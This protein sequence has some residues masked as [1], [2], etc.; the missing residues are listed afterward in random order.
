M[1]GHYVLAAG[2]ALAA[3][4]LSIWL[5]P[6]LHGD[7]PFLLLTGAVL[8]AAGIGGVGPGLTATALCAGFSMLL[9]AEAI[10]PAATSFGAIMFVA[11]GIGI[12]VLSEGPRRGIVRLSSVNEKLRIREGH[13]AAVLGMAPD[14]IV[15]IDGDGHI[16][17]FNAAAE[18]LF[19]YRRE[20]VV[21]QN[22]RI[23]MP[24]P[25]RDEHDGYLRHYRETGDRKI[26]GTGRVVV[27]ERKNGSTFPMSLDV[28]EMNVDGRSLFTGFVKD[29]TERQQSDARLHELRAELVHAA[30][31][32]AMGE[33]ASALAHE[34]NQPLSAIANYMKGLLRSIQGRSSLD[35]AQI[36]TA[37][38]KA[39][40]QALRA[41]GIVRRLRDFVARGETD[42]QVESLSKLVNEASALGLV[43]VQQSGVKP[44]ISVPQEAGLVLV[45]R[46]QIQQVLFNLMRNAIEAMVEAQ[47]STRMLL[48]TARAVDGSLVE[49]SVADTG[50]GISPEVADRLFRPFT[51][52][53]PQGMGLGL[54]ISRTIVEAHGGR[55]WVEAAEGGG[56]V[57]RFT[58][59]AHV[60]EG[61][62]DGG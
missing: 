41:G 54:S 4:G 8:V 29:L 59:R 37:L 36:A 60:E 57:F 34:L 23:L 33:M 17:S 24:S 22:V 50:P 38:D 39:G 49:I 10:Q 27:G 15:T 51:T 62:D 42:I 13:L 31:V 45:D 12:S 30:R 25:Y 6:A 52:T 44:Q 2:A 11:I 55:L 26:I 9:P 46:V 5:A 48:L 19:G 1:L 40:E 7:T 53:K 43:G 16:H 18:R 28:G 35:T 58:V 20:E 56:A 32:A 61:H 14:A 47:S 3:L 21:G